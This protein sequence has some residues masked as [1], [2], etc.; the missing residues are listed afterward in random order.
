MPFNAIQK[1]KVR[2]PAGSAKQYKLMQAAA[3]G[4]LKGMGPSP[5]VAREMISKTP[6]SK[7]S[8]YS[9]QIPKKRKRL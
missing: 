5:T 4:N 7:R 2:M 3:R 9:S 8:H 6:S 1:E